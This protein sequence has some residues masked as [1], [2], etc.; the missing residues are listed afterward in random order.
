TLRV[1][2]FLDH[3]SPGPERP[4]LAGLLPALRLLDSM[5]PAAAGVRRPGLDLLLVGFLPRHQL[6]FGAAHGTQSLHRLRGSGSENQGF[7]PPYPASRPGSSRLPW[8]LHRDPLSGCG[9]R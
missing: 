6:L 9:E 7:I 4:A 8:G 1:T 5:D 3:D 2:A